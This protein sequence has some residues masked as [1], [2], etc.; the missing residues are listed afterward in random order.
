MLS[1]LHKHLHDMTSAYCD[2]VNQLVESE[3]QLFYGQFGVDRMSPA[4]IK[5]F[6]DDKYIMAHCGDDQC[7]FRYKHERRGEWPAFENIERM[8]PLILFENIK[9]SQ[10]DTVVTRYYEAEVLTEA[11]VSG[12]APLD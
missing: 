6:I 7:L 10:Q 12:A 4:T 5:G 2:Q 1:R 11:P 9:N 3:L 8:V